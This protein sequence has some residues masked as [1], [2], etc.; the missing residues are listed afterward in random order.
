MTGNELKAQ[1]RVARISQEGLARLLGISSRTI[2]RYE[3]LAGE[4]LKPI[5]ARALT[6]VIGDALRAANRAR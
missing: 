3:R 4:G 5:P 1:R 6:A 2:R